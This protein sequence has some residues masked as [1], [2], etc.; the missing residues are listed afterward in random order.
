MTGLQLNHEY[1]VCLIVSNASGSAGR[2][3]RFISRPLRA[4]EDRQRVDLRGAPTEARWKAAVKPEQPGSGVLLEYATN[5]AL[6]GATT[7]N[8]AAPLT[9]SPTSWRASP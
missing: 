9:G 1:T 2:R 7:G 3:R 8:G 5:E 6:T 4:A